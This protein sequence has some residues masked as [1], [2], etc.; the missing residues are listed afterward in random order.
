MSLH[1]L[2]KSTISARRDNLARKDTEVPKCELL[3]TGYGQAEAEAPGHRLEVKR[4]SEV[5]LLGSW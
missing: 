3:V 5:L 2:S 1:F 4:D